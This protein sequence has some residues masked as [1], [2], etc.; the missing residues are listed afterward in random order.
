MNGVI[1]GTD[2]LLSN[3]DSQ[4][5]T[6]EQRE[7]L[8]IVK[9]S[10]ES[11]LNLI[12]GILDLSKIE[13]GTLELDLSYFSIFNCVDIACDIVANSATLKSVAL[14][15]NIDPSVPLI[16]YSDE[17]RIKQILFNLISNAIKFS[18]SLSGEIMVSVKAKKLISSMDSDSLVSDWELEF[19]VS[20]NGIGISEA[21]QSKLFKS[22]S[23]IT[24]AATKSVNPSTTATNG[25][26]LGLAIA[27][28]LVQL[29]QGRIWMTSYPDAAP[30]SKFCFTIAAKGIQSCDVP[31][32]KANLH[33]IQEDSTSR[34]K[35]PN[36]VGRDRNS[37]PSGDVPN[38]LKSRDLVGFPLSNLYS[39]QFNV[40]SYLDTARIKSIQEVFRATERKSTTV[41]LIN[42]NPQMN[43]MLGS[44]ISR[45]I[46]PHA[47]LEQV[48]EFHTF[49]TVFNSSIFRKSLLTHSLL[50]FDCNILPLS[51]PLQQQNFV[52]RLIDFAI[53]S[54]LSLILIRDFQNQ[55]IPNPL[56]AECRNCVSVIYYP[57]KPQQLFQAVS[58][59]KGMNVDTIS[60]PLPYSARLT[61]E[62]SGEFKHGELELRI[63]C[64]EDSLIN[65]KLLRK[66]LL[67]IGYKE[68]QFEI[69]E[70]GKLALEAIATTNLL[71]NPQIP[72]SMLL[73]DL[74]MPTMDGFECCKGIRGLSTAIQQPFVCAVTAHA[75][76]ADQER[77]TSVGM[78]AFITKP[79]NIKEIKKTIQQ[80][81]KHLNPS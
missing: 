80:A 42:S 69:V 41:L 81:V 66:I 19:C 28:S 2:L 17:L 36:A 77:C 59:C 10:G 39:A 68:S 8:L 12:A 38:L 52:M 33:S 3:S 57:L 9:S 5:L 45:W 29:L 6:T 34:A 20:D 50:V 21:D 63:L 48:N 76:V 67:H 30:G 37:G 44:L 31:V 61:S 49:S 46:G 58:T 24:N 25:A 22:F 43:G 65:Q 55:F 60:S 11:M 79:I 40:P 14:M 62:S 56:P 26:G 78:N 18:P 70:H 47:V 75:T 15:Y 13:A 7:L 35:S 64:A 72:Y 71:N 54:K 23:Q 16:I 32:M 4:T 1:A 51:M 27:R 53:E 73:L 74:S